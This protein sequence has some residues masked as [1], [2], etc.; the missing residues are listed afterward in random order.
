MNIVPWAMENVC[1]RQL[2][3]SFLRAFLLHNLNG[4]DPHL[5]AWRNLE[6][7]E[8]LMLTEDQSLLNYLFHIR[9]SLMKTVLTSYRH[10]SESFVA[11]FGMWCK[12]KKCNPGQFPTETGAPER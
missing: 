8:E 4:Q 12:L 1:F 9:I 10:K 6:N 5:L 11:R 7:L 3:L 2:V